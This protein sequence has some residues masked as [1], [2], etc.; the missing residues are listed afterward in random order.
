MVKDVEARI[1]LAAHALLMAGGVK[2]V[3]L[4]RVAAQAKLSKG[5]LLYHFESKDALIE[6]MLRSAL[7][8]CCQDAVPEAWQCLVRTL[9]AAWCVAPQVLQPHWGMVRRMVGRGESGAPSDG[10]GDIRSEIGLAFV[11]EIQ[12][13]G[14]L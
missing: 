13:A 11:A 10:M 3:T 8:G 14:E 9:I 6:A 1:V 2:A 12:R 7:A 4:E 5:A